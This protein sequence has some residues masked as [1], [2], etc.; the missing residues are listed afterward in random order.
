MTCNSRNLPAILLTIAAA[1]AFSSSAKA[2][3]F[4]SAV[5]NNNGTIQFILNQTADYNGVTVVF[6]SG[7]V[8]NLL[9]GQTNAGLQ[10]FPLGAHTNF[11]IYVTTTGNGSPV[12]ISSDANPN[13]VWGSPRGVASEYNPSFGYAFGRIFVD[14]SSTAGKGKGIFMLNA[15][16]S[17]SPRGLGPF[18]TGVWNASA[19]SPYRMR[20]ADDGTLY[21]GDFSTAAAMVWQFDPNLHQFT[22][23]VLG[24]IGENQGI[25][26]GTH[27]DIEGE[28][29]A[30][31]S[32]S[33]GNLVLFTA[34]PGLAAGTTPTNSGGIP[35]A[36]G[37]KTAAGTYNTIYRY[38]IGAGPLPYTNGPDLAIG[39]G[40]GSIRELVIDVA[41]HKQT[42]NI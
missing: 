6:D 9:A 3:S 37:Y 40:L 18:T 31:G 41:V 30:F 25:S 17:S 8:T 10:A 24:I 4:A 11:A 5:T 7:T 35:P 23:Q 12:L 39:L 26:A 14:N 33:G 29:V 13:S 16:G 21:V 32:I 28:P 15:D 42:G 1:A 20:V 27:A 22:N 34:D 19:S 2:S 36:L 38:T